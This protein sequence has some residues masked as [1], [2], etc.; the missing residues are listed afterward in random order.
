MV[1]LFFSPLNFLY[2]NKGREEVL[3]LS[4]FPNKSV[5]KF[6]YK[7]HNFFLLGQHKWPV[8]SGTEVQ[9]YDKIDFL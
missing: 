7:P 2:K 4:S 6:S 5:L 9:T 3:I 1:Q 8:V